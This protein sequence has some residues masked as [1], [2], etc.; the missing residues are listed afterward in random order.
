MATAQTWCGTLD[1]E[2]PRDGGSNT[3]PYC[4]LTVSFERA[5]TNDR[6]ELPPQRSVDVRAPTTRVDSWISAV[7]TLSDPDAGTAMAGLMGGLGVSD[8][9]LYRVLGYSDLDPWLRVAPTLLAWGDAT[10]REAISACASR[11]G[12]VGAYRVAFTISPLGRALDVQVTPTTPPTD[13]SAD[14]VATCVREVIARTPFPCPRGAV[15]VPV[16]VR[17]CVGAV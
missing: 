12:G 7:A 2:T 15:P 17:V 8:A 4:T 14:R 13:G 10:P 16:S 9:P 11:E 3:R 6:S 1:D 5:G